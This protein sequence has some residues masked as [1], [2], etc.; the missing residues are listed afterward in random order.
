MG[1]PSTAAVAALRSRT[2]SGFLAP[3]PSWKEDL[4]IT[5]L[6][7]IHGRPPEAVGQ[8]AHLP[9]PATARIE[10]D[11]DEAIVD[12]RPA[13]SP[14]VRLAAHRFPSGNHPLH[15]RDITRSARSSR[16]LPSASP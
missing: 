14:Q 11:P 10:H 9:A 13:G 3:E 12:P 1:I 5:V 2:N 4:T 7:K 6:T 8:A 16:L 15:S